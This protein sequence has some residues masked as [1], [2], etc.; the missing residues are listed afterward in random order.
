MGIA[1]AGAASPGEPGPTG[2]LPEAGA[3]LLEFAVMVEEVGGPDASATAKG[4]I[5]SIA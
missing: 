1:G 5:S 3:V 4:N 2:D